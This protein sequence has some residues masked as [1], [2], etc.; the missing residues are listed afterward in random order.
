MQLQNIAYFCVSTISVIALLIYGQSIIVPFLLGGLL[1]FMMRSLKYNLGRIPFLQKLPSWLISVFASLTLLGGLAL[2][3][4]LI[5]ANI[6]TLSQSTALY[7]SNIDKV[8]EQINTTFSIDVF[9][10]L[11]QYS[12]DMDFTNIL[13]ALFT[14]ISDVMGNAFMILLFAVFILAEEA[15]FT[16]KMKNF[17]DTDEAY[18]QYA[19]L[20]DKTEDA[21]GDY[22]RLKTFVSLITGVASYLTLLLIGVQSPAF[23]AFL[24]FLLNFIPTVGSL[25]ATLFPAAFSLLQFGELTPFLLVLIIVGAIQV[26]VGNFLEPK[27]M[28]SSMNI[29]P[30]VTIIAL[31]LWGIIWGV[32]GMILS[33]PITVIMI[34]VMAQFES[35]RKVAILLSEKGSFD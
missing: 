24:I 17:F 26:V 3:F 14:S 11:Q 12:G 5:L 27:I 1:W 18:Q 23:W 4:N 15:F 25:I 10:E 30:L 21:I 35:T 8:V 6:N 19:Y 22:F 16:T 29:S 28:G 9:D 20:A 7:Q 33:V 32:I 31:S 34:I 2:F 13:N